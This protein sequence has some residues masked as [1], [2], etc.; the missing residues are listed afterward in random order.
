MSWIQKCEE[1]KVPIVSGPTIRAK[2]MAIQDALRGSSQSADLLDSITFSNGWLQRFQLRH[3]LKSR[4]VYGE[5]ASASQEDVD[6]G[7]RILRHVTQA[8]AKQ[9]IFNLD[10][11]AYFYCSAQTKTICTARMP[12]RKMIKKR[13]T[14]AVTS[15]SDGS[16][17]WPLL[18]VGSA[19]HPRCFKTRSARDL[20]LDYAAT[21]KAWMTGD[22]F[23]NWI[24]E[25][26]KTMQREGRYV[27]LLLDNASPH[28][29]EPFL[30]NVVV[31]M[32]P[33]NT[34]AF[35]QPQDAGVIQ[36]FKNKIGALRALHIVEKFDKLVATADESDKENFASLVNKLHEVSLLQAMEWAKEAWHSVTQDTIANCWR[37]TGI[38]DEE[39]YELIESM[40]NL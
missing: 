9:D 16:R 23:S 4:R 39:M 10:E 34:T 8:Y 30:S 21:K 17:R 18:F 6:E 25:F 32:L 7:R 1:W 36:A 19:K 37:H 24:E 15:N 11:T 22:V 33:A 29:Y 38:L 12:G 40:N 2:A 31:C 27:L 3:N 28:R 14:V 5:A 20:D 35:L 26:N 13:I